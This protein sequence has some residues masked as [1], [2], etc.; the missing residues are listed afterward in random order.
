MD[1]CF[2]SAKSLTNLL[3][4]ITIIETYLQDLLPVLSNITAEPQSHT[5]QQC[6]DSNARPASITPVLGLFYHIVVCLGGTFVKVE[7]LV[8]VKSRVSIWGWIR[9]H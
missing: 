8:T 1:V 6:E 5:S 9:D 4:D 7:L 2:Y 3:S